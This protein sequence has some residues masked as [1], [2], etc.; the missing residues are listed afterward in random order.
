MFVAPN[1]NDRNPGSQEQPFATIQHGMKQLH[2]GDSLYRR[3]GR[4]REQVMANALRG[5]EA[6]P[7]RLRNFP[8]ETIIIDGTEPIAE[9]AEG[10]WTRESG[11][12]ER[13]HGCRGHVGGWT[14]ADQCATGEFA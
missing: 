3:G 9:L 4:Y 7:I 6:E 12:T 14:L 2:A 10:P 13:L 11:N 5:T 1:G 8:G